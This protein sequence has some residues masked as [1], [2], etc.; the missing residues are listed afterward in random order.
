MSNDELVV[1]GRR[2]RIVGWLFLGLVYE[3]LTLDRVDEN[4]SL[5]PWHDESLYL[6]TNLFLSLDDV[7]R[8]VFSKEKGCRT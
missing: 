3:V 6:F 7:W 1:I 5:W 2:V 8:P 4:L